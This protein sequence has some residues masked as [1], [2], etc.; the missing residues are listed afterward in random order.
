MHLAAQYVLA[1][2]HA[3]YLFA[4]ILTIAASLIVVIVMLVTSRAHNGDST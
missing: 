3:P 4:G 1:I 2:D